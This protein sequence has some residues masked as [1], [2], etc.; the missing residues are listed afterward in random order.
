MLLAAVVSQS[1]NPSLLHESR[2][3]KLLRGQRL[4]VV[5][6]WHINHTSI[7]VVTHRDNMLLLE[8]GGTMR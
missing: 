1:R 2:G 4:R 6:C 3:D 7:F 8:A 5:I